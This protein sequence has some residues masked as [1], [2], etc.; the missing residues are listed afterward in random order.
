[1]FSSKKFEES[2]NFLPDTKNGGK[3]G[4]IFRAFF[5]YFGE[6]EKKTFLLTSAKA[7]LK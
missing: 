2:L 1:V 5:S 3:K 7:N 6:R 4:N